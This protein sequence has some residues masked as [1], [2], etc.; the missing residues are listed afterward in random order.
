MHEREQKQQ[1]NEQ[2]TRTN[3]LART[4]MAMAEDNE[5]EEERE[6]SKEASNLSVMAGE[7]LS[8]PGRAGGPSGAT[9]FVAEFSFLTVSL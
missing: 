4:V 9:D 6:R 7:A 2:I 1:L 8:E 3:K 5:T